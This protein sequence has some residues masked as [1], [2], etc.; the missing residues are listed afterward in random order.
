M[1]VPPEVDAFLD[2]VITEAERKAGDK[3]SS[4]EYREEMISELA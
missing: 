4:G 3:P 1:Q 2:H